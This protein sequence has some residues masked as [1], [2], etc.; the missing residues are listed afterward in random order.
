MLLLAVLGIARADADEMEA[1]ERDTEALAYRLLDLS[2]ALR[3]GDAEAAAR[4]AAA[5]IDA[6]PLPTPSGARETRPLGL[7]RYA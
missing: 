6:A 4:L 1:M 5:T 3:T 2:A 7:V